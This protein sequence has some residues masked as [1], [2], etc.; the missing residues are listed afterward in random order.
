MKKFF[1]LVIMLIFTLFAFADEWQDKY[2]TVNNYYT[3]GN[4]EMG[5][6]KAQ[7]LL[8]YTLNKY[9]SKSVEAGHAYNILGLISKKLDK[10]D[11]SETYFNKSITAFKASGDAEKKNVAIVKTNLGDLYFDYFY[12]DLATEN[13]LDAVNWFEENNSYGD[14]NEN[15]IMPYYDLY[16]IYEYAYDYPNAIK[17]MKKMIEVEEKTY[18]KN[19]TLVGVDYRTLAWLYINSD[20]YEGAQPYFEKSLSVLKVNGG[21]NNNQLGVTYN[22]YGVLYDYTGEYNKALEYYKKATEVF[23]KSKNNIE[24]ANTYNNMGLAYEKLGK[25]SDAKK[26]YQKAYDLSKKENGENNEDTKKYKENLDR[27]K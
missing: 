12:D 22:D 27:V 24:L 13:L 21:Y 19:D 2:D 8:D 11:E 15:L 23:E 16:Q 26:Y 10:F 1:V 18:G 7:E 6:K 3:N 20:D 9:D 17:Y 14:Y 25:K 5:Y 4:Y